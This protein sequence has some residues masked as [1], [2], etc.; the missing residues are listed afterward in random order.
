MPQRLERSPGIGGAIAPPFVLQPGFTE[1]RN[2]PNEEYFCAAVSSQLD[3]KG[4]TR[5][6]FKWRLRSDKV[7]AR[8]RMAAQKL[9]AI[10][11]EDAKA[12][13]EH[14]KDVQAS[15]RLLFDVKKHRQSFYRF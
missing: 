3:D 12:M 7:A 14:A 5:K 9:A 13:Q 2:P 4:A 15:L 11:K 1:D 10:R 8:R 6:S